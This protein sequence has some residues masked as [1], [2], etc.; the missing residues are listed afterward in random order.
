MS[1]APEP[2]LVGL[3]KTDLKLDS[4]IF[5]S[6]NGDLDEPVMFIGAWTSKAS[7]TSG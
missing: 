3:N 2:F 1:H 4:V 6:T 7:I 5:L